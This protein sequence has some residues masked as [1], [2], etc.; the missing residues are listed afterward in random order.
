[1]LSPGKYTIQYNPLQL[2]QLRQLQTPRQSATA[3]RES[4]FAAAFYPDPVRYPGFVRS[5]PSRD[6][7]RPAPGDVVVID[8]KRNAP[9][10]CFQSPGR[11]ESVKSS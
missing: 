5:D 6:S 7:P 11:N 10:P 4:A 9:T 8:S 1:M 3:A 2:H